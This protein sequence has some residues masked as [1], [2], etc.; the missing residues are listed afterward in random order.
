M[1]SDQ[2]Q[3]K[4]FLAICGSLRSS[5]ANRAV[6]LA[7]RALAS[8]DI[9]IDL[10]EGLATL[11]H[12]N[13]DWDKEEHDIPE[14][15]EWRR[16][17]GESAA[18]IISSPEYAHG[19][20]GS[21]K[22]ALDWLVGSLEFP[23]KPVILINTSPRS[24][25]AQNALREILTTMSARLISEAFVTLPLTS[26]MTDSEEITAHPKWSE[27]LCDSLSILKNAL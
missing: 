15:R 13:P 9:T 22:N 23:G 14:V 3:R 11:P 27:W 5:S 12:F 26:Q 19:L 24:F 21:L 17:V 10:F 4:R 8:S 20:P 7:M 2:M 18:L 1:I 16:S 6:L 25:H